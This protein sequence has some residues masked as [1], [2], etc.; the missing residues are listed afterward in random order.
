MDADVD[1]I[2][3]VGA[4]LGR[5]AFADVMDHRYIRSITVSL[6]LKTS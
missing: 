2:M 3:V 4:I 1:G 5:S 6:D